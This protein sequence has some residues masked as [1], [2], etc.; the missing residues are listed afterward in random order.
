MGMPWGEPR[1]LCGRVAS[2]APGRE[3]LGVLGLHYKVLGVPRG[4]HGAAMGL[5]SG[6]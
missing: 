4:G 5:L 2:L 3:A 6:P 1:A